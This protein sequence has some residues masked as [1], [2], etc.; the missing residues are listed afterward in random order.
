MGW[1]AEFSLEFGEPGVSTWG[2]EI[3]R[4][5]PRIS[6]PEIF[7]ALIFLCIRRLLRKTSSGIAVLSYWYGFR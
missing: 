5:V 7:V 3:G 6:K 4:G 2:Y 1:G